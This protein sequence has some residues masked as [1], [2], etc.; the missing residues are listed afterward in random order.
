MVCSAPCFVAFIAA[1]ALL[2]V[3]PL[4]DASTSSLPTDSSPARAIVPTVSSPLDPEVIF[5]IDRLER[6]LPA[7]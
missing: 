2:L 6:R 4:P 7:G 3:A 5:E 1:L